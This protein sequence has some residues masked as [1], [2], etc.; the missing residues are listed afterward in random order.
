M[1]AFRFAAIGLLIFATGVFG[2]RTTRARLR[3]G[4]GSPY[5]QPFVTRTAIQ[6]L[7]T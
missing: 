7:Q 4:I 5:V 3:R 6:P 1:R 2:W